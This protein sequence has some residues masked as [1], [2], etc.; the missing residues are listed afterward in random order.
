MKNSS[1]IIFPL[2]IISIITALGCYYILKEY[3]KQQRQ[4]NKEAVAI[5]EA[6][7]IV[8]DEELKYETVGILVGKN[9]EKELLTFQDLESDKQVSYAFNGTTK[10]LG[11]HGNSLSLDQLEL[12]EI[13]DISYSVHSGIIDKL[14]ISGDVWTQS[15]VTKFEI[16]EKARTMEIGNTLYKMEKDVLVSYGQRLAKLIDI[17]SVDTLTVKGKD[18]K[19]YSIIVE[20]GHGYLRLTNDAYFIG[21]WIEVG[22]EIIKPISEAMLLP[23]PEG[24]YHIRIT[25]KGYAGDEDIKIERDKETKVDLSDIELKE[26][27]IGHIQ[28]KISPEYAQLFVDETMTDF[29]ERVPLEYGIHKV[30]VECAGHQPVDTVIKVTSEY[31]D[32][33]IEL[34][35]KEDEDS[36]SSSSNKSSS[37]TSMNT[38]F[39][40]TSSTGLGSDTGFGMTASSASSSSTVV[41]KQP[42]ST[43]VTSFVTSSSL[44]SSSSSSSSI[45][46]SSMRKDPVTELL[47]ELLAT[48]DSMLYIEAPVGASV[49]VDGVY[50]GVAPTGC[51]KLSGTHIVTLSALGY[52]TKSYT[53]NV[54]NDDKDMTLSFS[55]L[56]GAFY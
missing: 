17:T 55:D 29:D 6:E 36:S 9:L 45:T 44:S 7:E 38:N 10:F 35:R 4:N 21:G 20:K 5:E 43:T 23:V 54:E 47:E 3:S 33:T 28:F 27:A 53:I 50:V 46:S 13:V 12:G 2:L 39:G 11:K 48:G 49:Y 40:I 37:S 15:G 42:T 16:N 56:N 8:T 14:Q 1:R 24:D 41:I 34:D 31:A 30:H 19:V 22:Q 25:N 51:K 32:V 52:E 26:V 18:R